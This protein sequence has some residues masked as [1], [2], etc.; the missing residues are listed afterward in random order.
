[1]SA[2]QEVGGPVVV[3]L[4][5]GRRVSVAF[6]S[7]AGVP[8]RVLRTWHVIGVGEEEDMIAVSALRRVRAVCEEMVAGMRSCRGEEEGKDALAESKYPGMSYY[9]TIM[10]AMG[11]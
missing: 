4:G 10:V 6:R 7:A 9:F 5:D 3:L 11:R 2:D 8:E 1:M